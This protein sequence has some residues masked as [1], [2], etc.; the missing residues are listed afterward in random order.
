[1]SWTIPSEKIIKPAS[2]LVAA[3]ALSGILRQAG[4]YDFTARDAEGLNVLIQLVGDIYAVL[5]AFA[6]FVI[7]GQF[8]EVENCVI[9]EGDS[10]ADILRLGA[11][12][13]ADDRATIRRS[14]AAYT[15]QVVQYEWQ[16]LGDGMRDEQA[17]E[18][19]SRFLN[20]VVEV[21]PRGEAEQLI[22]TRVLDLAARIREYHDERVAKT[23]TRIPP[24]LAGL[25]NTI[26]GVLRLLIFVYPFHH[27]LAS[28]SCIIIIAVVLFLAN[29]VMMDTDNPLKGAWN[30]S[31]KP[32]SDLKI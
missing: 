20:T 28:A 29:F 2:G 10:L 27:W 32:F 14:M 13:N 4:F 16:S 12:L 19:F 11:Y 3:M 15:H 18:F 8:T 7:W 23:L 25:V 9:R 21:T 6:I 26:A 1:M 24:T 5:L 22:H 17:D 30:V 31:S